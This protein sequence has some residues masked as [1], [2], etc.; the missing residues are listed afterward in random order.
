MIGIHITESEINA[1]TSMVMDLLSGASLHLL[2]YLVIFPLLTV[3]GR[4]GPG[5]CGPGLMRS[6]QQAVRGK[7]GLGTRISWRTYSITQ[8]SLY[9]EYISIY[10]LIF[11]YSVTM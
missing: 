3:T 8:I 10:L 4:C 9:L 5:W 7:S 6:A 11:T 1:N 2:T